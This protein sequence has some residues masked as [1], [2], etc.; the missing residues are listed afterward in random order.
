VAVL[1]DIIGVDESGKGDFFGPLVVAAC[2][3]KQTQLARLLE[4]GVRDSKTITETKLLGID[5]KLR[6]EFPHAILILSPQEYNER[7]SRIKNL[8][9]LLA[10]C[11]AEVIRRAH[12]LSPAGLAISDQFGKADL[13][14]A[15][16]AKFK[17]AISF[18]QLVRGEQLPQV[19]AAS[20]LARAAFIREM[21]SLSKHYGMRI[22]KGAAPVVDT[23]GR[24]LVA[25]YGLSVLPKV[26]KTHFKNSERVVPIDRL[27]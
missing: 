25:R 18:K 27:V 20:I 2:S 16:L 24:E 4:L 17:V 12:E 7:Y 26:A 15:E 22:P 19:A 1:S 21:V 13:I 5:E 6:S 23:A 14:S 9:K 10:W 3:V 11:H 8:N